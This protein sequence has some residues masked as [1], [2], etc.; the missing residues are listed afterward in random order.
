MLRQPRLPLEPIRREPSPTATF[1]ATFPEE[2][3]MDY[4]EDSSE[5]N[6]ALSELNLRPYKLLSNRT[7]CLIDSSIEQTS[8]HSVASHIRFVSA[9]KPNDPGRTLRAALCAAT[10]E[11]AC[12]GSNRSF[13]KAKREDENNHNHLSPEELKAI[14]NDRR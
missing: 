8:Q 1:K 6:K 11:A 7:R 2:D 14:F 10:T 5:L 9:L 13:E 12:A 4:A 3:V